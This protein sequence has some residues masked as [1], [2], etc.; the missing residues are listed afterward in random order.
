MGDVD[1]PRLDLGPMEGVPDRRPIVGS[2][3]RR[4]LGP[5]HARPEADPGVRRLEPVTG[6]VEQDPAFGLAER[7]TEMARRPGSIGM[8]MEGHLA[9]GR[10]ELDEDARDRTPALGERRPN[11]RLRDRLDHCPEG[12]RAH[13]GNLDRAQSL[14]GATRFGVVG[15]R[16]RADPVLRPPV[17][18]TVRLAPKR[19][20]QPATFVEAVE[21][22]VAEPQGSAGG[23]EECSLLVHRDTVMIIETGGSNK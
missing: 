23:F 8:G 5:F 2:D 7:R 14:L 21:R 9:G 12:H 1:L 15:H 19:P 11:H 10:Q 4:E 6:R 16:A 17:V 18:R 20:R 13:A 22:V 3:R